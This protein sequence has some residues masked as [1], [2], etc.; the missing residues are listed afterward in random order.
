MDLVRQAPLVLG[1]GLFADARGASNPAYE[2]V[3]HVLAVGFHATDTPLETDIDLS[4]VTAGQAPLV[5]LGY[6][7]NT[8]TETARASF[9]AHEGTLRLTRRCA[10]GV[11]GILTDALLRENESVMS[12]TPLQGGCTTTVASIE[13]DIENPCP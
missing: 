7:V 1:L 11:G 3:A 10:Q 2:D 6:E 8:E 12:S 4:M 5:G 9:S 13:F